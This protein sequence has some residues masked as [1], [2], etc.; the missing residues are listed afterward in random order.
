MRLEHYRKLYM[1]QL[2][3]SLA[4]EDKVDLIEQLAEKFTIK[5]WKVFEKSLS[6]KEKSS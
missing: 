2:L 4:E 5:D 1:Q 3:N 6:E